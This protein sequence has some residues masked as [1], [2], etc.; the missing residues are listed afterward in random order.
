VNRIGTDATSFQ[1]ESL[2]SF[3]TRSAMIDRTP[4]WTPGKATT[5]AV[6]AITDVSAPLGL[7]TW[8]SLTAYSVILSSRPG[9]A[10]LFMEEVEQPV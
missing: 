6:N 4:G 10:A 1:E 2:V 3:V 9:L 7:I 8:I 5:A